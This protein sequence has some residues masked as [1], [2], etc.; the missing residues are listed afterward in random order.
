MELLKLIGKHKQ[1]VEDFIGM[2]HTSCDGFVSF[3]DNTLQD[4]TERTKAIGYNYQENEDNIYLSHLLAYLLLCE[5]G[6]QALHE[7]DCK[8]MLEV[9]ENVPM[10]CYFEPTTEEAKTELERYNK[11]IEH[12][13][14][15]LQNENK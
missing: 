14:K 11:M 6:C 9:Y 4:W 8:M 12:D 3:M 15:Y 13:N 5:A 7:F 10:C 2:Y 1:K